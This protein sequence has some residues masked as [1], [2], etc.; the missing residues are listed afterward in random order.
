MAKQRVI[1]NRFAER[2]AVF[3]IRKRIRDGAL[4]QRDAHDAVRYP[5]EVQYF[6]DEINSRVRRTEQVS[7]AIFQFYFSG[8]N[9]AG[10]DFVFKAPDEV[11]ELTIFAI[12]RHEEQCQAAHTCRSSFGSRRY[13]G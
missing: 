13:N 5:R 11:V 2:S 4:R 3:G 6:E 9:G 10:G 12:A 7:L 8:R 1:E